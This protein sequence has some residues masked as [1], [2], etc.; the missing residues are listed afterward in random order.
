MAFVKK[1]FELPQSWLFHSCSMGSRRLIN[2]Q[3]GAAQKYK[4]TTNHAAGLS[5]QQGAA[6]VIQIES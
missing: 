6:S 2:I 1:T 3:E 4:Q 5:Q